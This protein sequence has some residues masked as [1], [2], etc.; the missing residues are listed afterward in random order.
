[1]TLYRTENKSIIKLLLL[2]LLPYYRLD[3][4]LCF[5]FECLKSNVL[6]TFNVK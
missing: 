3:F 1:M 4:V 2:L 6:R 5:N